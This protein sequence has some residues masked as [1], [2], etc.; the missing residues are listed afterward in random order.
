[1]KDKIVDDPDVTEEQFRAAVNR[2]GPAAREEAFAAG[3]P[4]NIIKNGCIVAQYAD[5]TEKIVEILPE[6]RGRG[7]MEPGA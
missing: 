4:V 3:L 2:V 1:M 7:M 6:L 5:G